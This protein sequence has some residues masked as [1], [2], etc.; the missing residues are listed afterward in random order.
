MLARL[1]IVLY[2]LLPV[3]LL[4]NH[5]LPSAVF[6]ALIFT[7]LVLLLRQRFEGASEQTLRYWRLIASYCV[8]FL[9]VVVSS[10]YYGTWAGANSEGALRIFL[11]LWV[12]LLA[13]PHINHGVLR[14]SLWGM[15][16]ACF[17]ST[18]IL[19]W[20]TIVVQERPL[21]PGVILTTYSSIMLLLGAIS[22]YTLKW[23]LTTFPRWEN[24]VK[25]LAVLVAFGGFWLA[26]T[27]TGLLGLPLFVLLGVMLFVG[28]QRP[29]RLLA[30]LGICAVVLVA[31]LGSNEVLSDRIAE[32]FDQVQTCQS[33]ASTSFNSMCIRLQLWRSAI[34]AGLNHPWVGLGD[35]GR[36]HEYLHQVALPKGLVSERVVEQGFGE[37][38]N[39]L[40]LV[41]AGFGF[42]GVLGLL[43]IYLAPCFYFL[44]R[45]LGKSISQQGRAA[46]AMGLATCLGFALFGLTEMMFRRMNTM[47]FYVALVALF[48][49]LS[50][51][52]LR[53]NSD[54]PSQLS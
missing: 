49:V 6:Y 9:A 3:A 30:V 47:G 5:S 29:R 33:E 43:L 54:R 1:V 27:R 18:A 36:F 52:K 22:V 13:L 2:A 11:G 21:T 44:P 40:M 14:Q 26:Q 50:D 7:A 28:V 16:I 24:S 15:V 4:T 25:I 34:D 38:H 35:G 10:L 48:M 12:L 20:L 31:I 41:F 42:P 19:V 51:E 37:P 17:I 8:L 46:A 53:N 45:F 32:G 39:D 23:P